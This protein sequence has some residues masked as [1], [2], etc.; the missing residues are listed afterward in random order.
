MS[1]RR[2]PAELVDFL[3][4]G[5]VRQPEV[6]RVRVVEDGRL[7]ELETAQEDRGRVIGRQ[8]RVAKALRA[9]VAASRSGADVQLEI[10]D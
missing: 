7:L 9:L 8:G 10:V 5:I 3:A 4:K 2:T 6:V 1:E